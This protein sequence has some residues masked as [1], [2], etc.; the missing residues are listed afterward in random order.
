[1]ASEGSVYQK[2]LE[3]HFLATVLL[4]PVGSW[5]H[6]LGPGKLAKEGMSPTLCVCS[7][8]GSGEVELPGELWLCSLS[9]P[10]WRSVNLEEQK[11]LGHT[12]LDDGEFWYAILSIF[13]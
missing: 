13:V 6:V 8:G 10:E 7:W 3:G 12:A 4:E 9:S 1:M 5:P 2:H 11:R